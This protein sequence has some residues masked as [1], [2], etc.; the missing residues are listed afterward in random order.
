[1]AH[2]LIQMEFIMLDNLVYLFLFA[3]MIATVISLLSPLFYLYWKKVEI[4]R[5]ERELQHIIAKKA[6]AIRIYEE[7]KAQGRL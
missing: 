1:M 2:P 5:Q 6:Q 7:R 4:E 3:G